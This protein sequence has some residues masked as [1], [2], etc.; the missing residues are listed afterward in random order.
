MTSAVQVGASEETNFGSKKKKMLLREEVAQL[1]DEVHLLRQ[2]KEMLSKDLEDSHG[3]KSAEIL[4]ATELK[5][6]LAQK[7]QE[8]ARAKES[9]QAMKADRKRLKIEKAELVNQ[10]QQL[11]ATL[12]SRE[13]QLRDFIRNYEQHRKESEDAVKALA[14]EKDQLEREKWDLR[15]QAKEATDHA[16]AL[17]SQL[18]LKENRIKE[19]EAELAMAKQSLA[20]LTKDVPK[21]HS[22]A[23]PPETVL[24]GNQE[25]VIQ[26]DLPLTAAIRQSQQTLYHGHPPHPGERQ[27]VRVS[28]CH[29]RQPSIIS[30]ASAIEGDRSS[31][32]SDINSPRHRTHSLCNS[33]EDLEDQK[34]KKKK[35]KMGLGSLSRVFAR[36]KQRKSLD[37]GLFDGTSTPDYYIEEDA[38][39]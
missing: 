17:R 16:T 31:T 10:M 5:V 1:Q 24:N 18:D 39:W 2:M 4:S 13:E 33:L 7:E 36:G 32:P 20:T 3:G 25:W 26:A 27:A 28:P 29:S 35:E 8:L 9:L 21:R 15:Q 23:M 19:L 11:Y 6:Q 30:D 37:P 14:K 12:E 38:D 34:R 22:L